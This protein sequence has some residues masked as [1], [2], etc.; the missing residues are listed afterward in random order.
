MYLQILM[1]GLLKQAKNVVKEKEQEEAEIRKMIETLENRKIDLSKQA[2]T[3]Q[4]EIQRM[5][6]FFEIYQKFKSNTRF[7]NFLP[8]KFHSNPFLFLY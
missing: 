3:T 1:D 2:E 5:V 7:L 8:I 4:R 6:I